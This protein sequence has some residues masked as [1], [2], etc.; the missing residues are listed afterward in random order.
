MN[1]LI[2]SPFPL[3][4]LILS[5][6]SQ[7][8]C[9][10][11]CNPGQKK[12]RQKTNECNEC[13]QWANNFVQTDQLRTHLKSHFG[14]ESYRFNKCDLFMQAV[15]G[16]IWKLTLDKNHTTVLMENL[17]SSVQCIAYLTPIPFRPPELA[18]HFNLGVTCNSS[19]ILP[20]YLVATMIQQYDCPGVALCFWSLPRHASPWINCN[21]TC[22]SRPWTMVSAH[23]IM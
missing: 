3:H 7:P 14:E 21:G 15:W 22:S 11:L 20:M 2:L 8:G 23:I 17:C 10:N 16:D 19:V 12:E 9:H 6:F 4:F 1:S 5:I 18:L 13:M